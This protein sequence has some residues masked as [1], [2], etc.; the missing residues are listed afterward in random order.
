MINN[1]I[2]KNQC[3]LYKTYNLSQI[4]TQN[5]QICQIYVNIKCQFCV[6][7]EKCW[8]KLTWFLILGIL[9]NSNKCFFNVDRKV[10]RSINYN[11]Y[12]LGKNTESV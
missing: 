6:S 10:H 9:I 2:L 4:E 1:Y 5:G 7:C 12:V 3:V 8:S 11:S